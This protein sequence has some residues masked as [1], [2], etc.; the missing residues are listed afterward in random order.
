[1]DSPTDLQE[2]NAMAQRKEPSS[3]QNVSPPPKP[4][5]LAHGSLSQTFLVPTSIYVHATNL[6][7]GFVASLPAATDGLVQDDGPSSVEELLAQFLGYITE[8]LG[9]T[10]HDQGVTKQILAFMVSHFDRCVLQRDDVHALAAT[11]P[12]DRRK[13]LAVIQAYYEACH[14]L[15]MHIQPCESNLLRGARDGDARIFAIFGGQ[16]NT[17]NYFGELSEMYVTYRHFVE[18]FISWGSEILQQLSQEPRA[19]KMYSR[20]LDAKGWLQNPDRQPDTGYLISAPVSFPLIG[21]LQLAQYSLTCKLLGTSPGHFRDYLAGLSGHSQGIVAAV[22]ASSADSWDSFRAAARTALTVLFW[23]GLRSQQTYP[24]TAM[25]PS[26]LQECA[27]NGEGSPTPMLSVRNLP[28]EPLQQHVDATNDHLPQ[29]RHVHISLINSAR[30]I[31]VSGPPMSLCGLN[32]RLRG[33]KP[34]AGLDQTRIPFTKRR[35]PFTNVFLPIT[36]PFHSPYLM[37]TTEQVVEDLHDIS[38]SRKDL[39]V[40]VYAMDNGRDLRTTDEEDLVPTLVKMIMCNPVEWL[41]A[42]T[43][44]KATHILDFGPGGSLGIGLITHQNKEGSGVRVISATSMSERNTDMG[45]KEELFDRNQEH[46]VKY[47]TDWR[48]QHGPRLIKTTT[49][50]TFMD[51]KFSRL[52]GLPP[53][54]VAGM[55]P[56]TVP[57]DFVA[58]TMNAGY[59][60]EL[61]GGGYYNSQDMAEAIRKIANSVIPGRAVTVNLIYVS[62]HAIAWQIPLIRQLRVEG[63]PVEGLTIGAGIPTPEVANEYITTLGLR[64]IAFKPGSVEAI[65]QVIN[66]AQVN[67]AFPIILQWTGGRGGGHHSF[68]DFHQPVLQMYGRI[69]ECSNIILVAGSGFGGSE[70]TYPYLTG[71]W[72]TKFNH[73]PMPFDGI[74]FGSRMMTAKEAHTSKAVKQAIVDVE[75]S[76]DSQWEKTYKGPSGGVMTV[77][78]EM[79]EPIHKLAT[80]G[81]QF[82]A[83]MD[84]K[85]FSLDR[86]KRVPELKKQRE[87]IIGKLNADFQ[88]VWFG[89]NSAGE[90]VDIEEMTYLETLRRMVDLLYVR[91]QSRWIDDSY[92]V[93]L[94]D[95]VRRVEERYTSKVEPSIVQSYSDL[96]DPFP[97]IEKV[98]GAYP[99]CALQL[100]NAQDVQHFLLLCQR[101]GQKPVP[102]VP[103]LDENF[104]SWFKK[105]SLWQSEDLE[106]V[107][108]QDVG[109]T[110]ILQGPV[111]AKYSRVIDEPIKDILDGICEAHVQTLTQELYSG[112]AEIPVVEYIGGKPI[113]YGQPAQP[114]ALLISLKEEA[115]TYH[116]SSSSPATVK[117][118]DLDHWLNLLAGETYSWR[119]ALFTT[120]FIVQGDKVVANPIRRIFVP[121]WDVTVEITF[122]DEPRKTVI[123]VRENSDAGGSMTD[124]IEVRVTSETDILLTLFVSENNTGRNVGLPLKFTYHPDAGFAPIREVMEGRNDRIKEF[125]HCLSFGD[126][127]VHRNASLT[128][129]FS[130]GT[131]T[132]KRQAVADFVHAIGN[133]GEAYVNGNGKDVY[134]P[135]DFAVKVAWKALMRPLFLEAMNG[136]LLKL[137]HLSNDFHMLPDVKPLKLDDVVESTSRI[138]AILNQDS[139]KMVEVCGTIHR[140]GIPVMKITSQFLYRGSYS[141]YENTF[142]RKIEA[143]MTL[144]LTSAKDVAQLKSRDWFHPKDSNIDLLDKKLMFRLE[145]LIRFK[146]RDLFSSVKTKGLV[147]YESSTNGIS[148][149]ATVEYEAGCSRGNPVIDYLE[150]HGLPME[151][152][153]M[154]DNVVPLSGIIP[155]SIQAPASNEVYAG[156]S[157]DHNPIHVSRVIANYVDLR[158]NI[159]HGMYTS[160]AVRGLVEIWAADNDVERVRSFKCSFVDMVL[161]NDHIEVKLWHVGM[162]SGRK[163]VKV[164][165]Y[166]NSGDK[167]LVGEA[168]VEQPVTAYIFTG[169][170]SQHLGMGMELY[171]QSEVAR[172]VW[173]R[174][175]SHLLELFGINRFSILKIIRENPKELT[176]H[177]GG[178]RGRAIRQRYMSMAVENTGSDGQMVSQRIFKDIDE[179][180]ESYTHR[181]PQGL[182]YSTQFAQPALTLMAKASFDVLQAKRLIPGQSSFAGH[183]LGEYAALAAFS[184]YMSIE[185]LVTLVFYRGLT[186]QVCVERDESGRTNY[187]MCALNPS[188]VSQNFDEQALRYVVQA[189]QEETQWLLEVVN[190]NIQNMQYTCTGDLRALDTL[191]SV[192]NYLK[193]HPSEIPSRTKSSSSNILPL[194]RACATETQSKPVPLELERGVAAIPLHGIDVPFHSTYLRSGVRPFRAILKKFIKEADVDP[195]MLIGRYIPNLTGK[196]FEITR[197]YFEE[198]GRLTESEEIDRILAEWDNTIG[199]ANSG[200]PTTSAMVE[201]S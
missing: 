11:L 31:V 120:D 50:K 68:E 178:P 157:G 146:N 143:P 185:D 88:K 37:T 150:R 96:D 194:I 187:S 47:A 64:H 106:A 8:L 89:R 39:K 27:R 189:I 133:F 78:S 36:A 45:S 72:A 115:L 29:D 140:K 1:M 172:E 61:A 121:A 76:D 132:V 124:V 184:K 53:V 152:P 159:T 197:E 126:Q 66:I 179:K 83:E 22:V 59:H 109:R 56:C 114:D 122:P 70:D 51:T 41:R 168:E 4:L 23:I 149:A 26:M 69:R 135:M 57:W 186:M 20:G 148:E 74:L 147:L 117:L 171:A 137:V 181:S 52:L 182:L 25:L 112:K 123:K 107:V 6:R 163:I 141:D 128:D 170:G 127:F 77:Q 18:D 125:Y 100:V 188:K 93:L 177:F 40:P 118:P 119:R 166:N 38:I 105:D 198:V 200:P 28:H 195:R 92:K 62:P 196:P 16:G 95:F 73:S 199:D 43:F 9:K 10:N 164:E 102:F 151:K 19:G 7:D 90:P 104:E 42:T 183:S 24:Q 5:Q 12:G 155:T 160:A 175:D 13:R 153:H 142:Q 131:F 44:P 15:D 54:M 3:S 103:A 129:S 86:S 138:E 201:V 108:D 180:T 161:P 111:A 99:A 75:G 81:V 14:V 174:A 17:D 169:Q 35:I 60:I 85:I 145:S 67:E 71:S 82:W 87:Y 101:R 158:G 116:L 192:T 110:C 191:I 154:F 136:D 134:A 176:I 63:V 130:G 32:S 58:A 113:E 167:V 94:G 79:R 139:G 144:H 2:R 49:G 46:P 98:L 156:V 84:E 34:T 55:T 173:D 193:T 30:N 97:L 33:L 21:L 91:H 165:A 65:Q 80:R 190:L 48:S 162:V